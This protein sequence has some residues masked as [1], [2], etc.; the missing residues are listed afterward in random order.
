M[1][2]ETTRVKAYLRLI[3]N[4]EF[5][6]TVLDVCVNVR[7]KFGVDLLCAGIF[8]R[9]SD[10]DKSALLLER[11]NSVTKQYRE[12]VPL[13]AG[14]TFW[15]E[16]EYASVENVNPAVYGPRLFTPSFLRE[17]IDTACGIGPYSSKPACIA[18]FQDCHA[19]Y[20]AALEVE[21]NQAR[22]IDLQE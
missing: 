13:E 3:L 21:P 16:V 6:Y 17:P 15:N 7:R 4:L 5:Q 12:Y 19:G 22:Q 8:F 18:G 10:I 14:R 2:S 1:K 9:C 20:S 11:I